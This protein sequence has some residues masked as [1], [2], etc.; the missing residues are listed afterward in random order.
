MDWKHLFDGLEFEY[1][2]SL[3]YDIHSQAGV[4]AYGLVLDWHDD[5]SREGHA[6]GGEFVAQALLV[7]RL[8][9]A[10]SEMP[11]HLNGRAYDPLCQFGLFQHGIG[12]IQKNLR[13]LR[14]PR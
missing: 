6:N 11:V 5:L 3:D 9:E 10:R 7:N 13:V 8:D 1:N 12:I 2:Q 14:S 4:E